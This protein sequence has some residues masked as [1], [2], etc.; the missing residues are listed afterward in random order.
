MAAS[1][2]ND[3]IAETPFKYLIPVLCCVL[4]LCFVF[5]T[6]LVVLNCVHNNHREEKK[7]LSRQLSQKVEQPIY[8]IGLGQPDSDIES[9]RETRIQEASE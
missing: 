1:Y 7:V 6:I 2:E 8:H 5:A 3:S 4:V 9:G